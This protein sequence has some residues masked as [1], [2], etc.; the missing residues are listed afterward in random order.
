M[1]IMR[2]GHRMLPI[3]GIIISLGMSTPAH[4]KDQLHTHKTPTILYF[5]FD[6]AVMKQRFIFKLQLTIREMKQNSLLTATINGHTDRAGSDAYNLR[7]SAR[8][9]EYVAG[10]IAQ[11]GI[12]PSRISYFAFGESDPA[13]ATADG[14]AEAKNRRVE[15]FLY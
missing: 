1:N 5:P 13:I 4:A 3:L 6:S 10:L 8:R 2:N 11:A 14:V 15:I 7:L 12:A 9:A